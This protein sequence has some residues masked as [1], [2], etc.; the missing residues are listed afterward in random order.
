VRPAAAGA[1]RGGSPVTLGA[2]SATVV[3]LRILRESAAMHNQQQ[4]SLNRRVQERKSVRKKKMARRASE[5][6][7]MLDARD[8]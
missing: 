4:S 1:R 8:L 5:G 3:N 6:D 7:V 2:W